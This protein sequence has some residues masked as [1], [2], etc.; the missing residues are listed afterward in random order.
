[1]LRAELS[2]RRAPVRRGN[3]LSATPTVEGLESRIL[4]WATSGGQ[5]AFGSRITYSFIPDATSI[6]GQPSI[7]FQTLNAKFTTASWEAQI[8]KAAAVW[9]AVANINIA[10]VSDDGT[11]IASAGDQQDDPRFGDIRIGGMSQSAGQLAFAYATPPFNGGTLAGDMFFNTDQSWAING[12]SN[13]DLETVAIHEF[14]HALGMS[15]SLVTAADM[16]AY[17]DTTT[18]KQG[19]TT[20]DTQGIQSIYGASTADSN[21][22]YN[23]SHATVI[24]GN[25]NGS[26][27]IVMPGFSLSAANDA[28]WFYV[29]VPTGAASTM[30]VSVQSS[31]LSSLSPELAVYNST[32]LFQAKSVMSGSF[33]GTA[34]VTLTGV[35]AGQGY[36]F[37]VLAADL[38]ASALG[39]YG[40]L[41]NFGTS[42]LLPIAPPNTLVLSQADQGGGGSGL[43]I[44]GQAGGTHGHHGHGN[45]DGSDQD[46]PEMITVGTITAA[47]DALTITELPLAS[48]A[49]SHAANTT[50]NT[51]VTQ[52]KA[53][54]V[55]AASS[56]DGLF[57]ALAHDTTVA[58][59][60]GGTPALVGLSTGPSHHNAMIGD[61]VDRFL[62]D[63][64]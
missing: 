32:P 13:Y 55:I 57:V 52:A 2:R 60:A 18:I 43:G 6:G 24:T 34:T 1:M 56:F 62:I 21:S 20:D 36:Y 54:P 5:W 38:G 15:H 39:T 48:T 41:A 26:K 4:L 49:I 12:S 50:L 17:Y 53:V 37:K 46:A 22:N 40:L 28:D 27:Q 29:V 63:Q 61:F 47:G 35:V 59:I 64:A 10:R 14:G 8:E 23:Y 3:A 42:T 9:E 16:Y 31:N 58:A 7:L 51:A 19:L 11:A 44:G 33:G 45:S 30:T 25:I